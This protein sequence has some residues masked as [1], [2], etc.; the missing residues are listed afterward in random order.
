MEDKPV[1]SVIGIYAADEGESTKAFDALRAAHLGEVRLFCAPEATEPRRRKEGDRYAALCLESECLLV[2]KAAPAKVPAIVRRLQSVGS[3]AVF[4]LPEELTDLAVPE[5]IDTASVSSEPVED[6]ARKCAKRRGKPGTTKPRILARLRNNE[7]TLETSR[8][9]LAEAARLEHALTASA[10]WLLDN[11]H[12]IRTQVA[13]IRRHL[14]R[15]HHE[16][17]PAG[18]S[19]APYIYELARE[20]V[21]HTD[22]SLNETKIQ[23]CLRAYQQVAPLTIAELWSF[24]LLLRT[25]LIEELAHL[26]LHVSHK[27][28]LREA[29][30]FWANR[31][32]AAARRTP[33]IFEWMLRQ[34]E[35]EPVALQPYFMTCLAEQ[36]QDE[37]D[38]LA[39]IQHWI[40]DRH[41]TTLTEMVRTEHTRE[42]AES[43]STA[44]SFNSLRALARIDFAEIFESVSLMDAELRADPSGIYAHSDFATRDRC[45]R[46]VER[47]SRYSGVGELDVAR[48]AVALARQGSDVRTQHVA[49]YL[50][51]EGVAQLEAETHARVP[52]GRRLIRGLRRRATGAYL[53]WIAGL[54]LSF[55]ALALA[56]A[57]DAGVHERGMLAVLGI[58]ALFPLSELA[59]QMVNALVISLLPPEPMP[60]MD[61]RDGIPPEHATLIVVPMMLS[62]ADVVRRELEKLEV[63]FLANQ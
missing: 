40:E 25:A 53:G 26:A 33:E 21:A 23:D 48:R 42:A 32:A 55:T 38:A 11:G 24:P 39:P 5:E 12:L 8:Q 7:L 50:L 17:L 43:V 58:L 41:Q 19:G 46:A 15:R 44:N 49:Y 9:D 62:S 37:E 4:V 27:Q 3:P 1:R 14:P 30:Y 2:A 61:F 18:A 20:L 13:E 51:D 34:M 28:Q 36:L 16:L 22:N 56:L 31:L 59:L 6:F 57:W 63:R 35:A 10:E 45:R 52:A 47:I 29:A 60:K 54:T